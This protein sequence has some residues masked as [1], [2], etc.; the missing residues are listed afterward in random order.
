MACFR[1]SATDLSVEAAKYLSSAK[2]L[3]NA[4]AVRYGTVNMV[5]SFVQPAYVLS[6]FDEKLKVL[7]VA[8]SWG[9]RWSLVL[10]GLSGIGLRHCRRI[11]PNASGKP[12]STYKSRYTCS[13]WNSSACGVP[14]HTWSMRLLAPVSLD[15]LSL[16]FAANVWAVAVWKARRL[17]CALRM[18]VMSAGMSMPPGAV[19]GEASACASDRRAPRGG[20]EREGLVLGLQY[21]QLLPHP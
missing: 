13:T 1:M 15:S 20:E 17:V 7:T 3:L 16:L 12:P 11:Q 2:S 18:A 10:W 8:I 14:A 4:S 6:P 5:M 21:P 9:V 19:A